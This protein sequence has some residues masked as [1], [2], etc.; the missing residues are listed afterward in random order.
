MRTTHKRRFAIVALATAAVFVGGGV[1]VAYWTTTGSG[2]GSVATGTSATVSVTQD[3]TITGLYPGGPAQDLDFT[4]T[5]PN[6]GAQYISAVAVAVTG[7]SNAGCTSADFQVTQPTIT[8]GNIAA[9]AT[10]YTGASTGASIALKNT[11]LNQNPCKGVTVNLS[12][13]VS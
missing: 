10:A 11:V 9:G 3:S 7:T 4:I 13:T 8:A 12:Y 1:A 2:T 5:N 6:P